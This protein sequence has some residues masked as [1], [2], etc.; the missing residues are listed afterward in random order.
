MNHIEYEADLFPILKKKIPAVIWLERG[1]IQCEEGSLAE[2][3][4]HGKH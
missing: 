2:S 3:V 4:F 1:H